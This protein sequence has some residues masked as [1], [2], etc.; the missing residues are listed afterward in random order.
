MRPP[1]YVGVPHVALTSCRRGVFA[2]PSQLSYARAYTSDRGDSPGPMRVK[3]ASVKDYRRETEDTKIKQ[4]MLSAYEKGG[5][6]DVLAG[7][8]S[9]VGAVSQ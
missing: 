6:L 4:A 2:R 5:V 3:C 7:S 9:S 8:E 1:S